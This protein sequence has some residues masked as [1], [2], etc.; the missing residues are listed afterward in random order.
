MK[1]VDTLLSIP[2]PVGPAGKPE[3]P[4]GIEPRVSELGDAAR[5]AS[6]SLNLWKHF[7]SVEQHP[8]QF[9]KWE[10]CGKD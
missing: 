8:E 5:V 2:K 4:L 1:G 10:W 6:L 3:T 7:L 9:G